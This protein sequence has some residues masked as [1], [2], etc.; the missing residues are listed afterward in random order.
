MRLLTVDVGTG[1]QDIL[2]FDSDLEVE[3]CFKMVM[4]SPTMMVARTV[5]A[6]TRRGDPL[7]LTGVTMGGGPST[8]ATRDHVQAGHAVYATPDAARSFNDDLDAVVAEMGIQ[9]V[10]ADE[11]LALQQRDDV[12]SVELRDFDYPAIARAFETFGLDLAHQHALDGVAVAVFDHGNAPPGYSDRQ[13]RF[14]Y[15]AERLQEREKK[16][17]RLSEFSTLAFRAEHIPPVMTRM[18]AVADGYAADAPLIVMDTAPAA[19]L[20]AMLDLQVGRRQRLIVANVGNFHTLAFRLGPRHIEGVF[21]HHT[22]LV[23]RERLDHLLASLADG[24]LTHQAI[25]DDHGHGALLYTQEPMPL[26]FVGI[27]GP[28]RGLMRASRHSPY[29]AVPY[30]DMMIAGCFG[31]V[32]VCA[33]LMPQWTEPILTSLA[34]AERGAPWEYL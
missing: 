26:D 23:D 8:W 27:T 3:N 18:Q 9:I 6:A 33:D 4:P 14:D 17:D 19:I 34:G 15:L 2:L 22:G 32:R 13:F 24:T 20:G 16:Q 7:L 1:T 11:A 10:G 5:K 29:F 30:G 25:F 28:R 21:E 31:L 12:V